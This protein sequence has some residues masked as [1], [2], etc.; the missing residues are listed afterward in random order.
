M[1]VEPVEQPGASTTKVAFGFK[2]TKTGRLAGAAAAE[3]LVAE[4]QNRR[5]QPNQPVAELIT[6]IEGDQVERL[7][8]QAASGSAADLDS[9]PVVPLLADK[10]DWAA[11]AKRRRIE[12]AA[13]AEASEADQLTKASPAVL[14]ILA[15]CQ[16]GSG[17]IGASSTN[18]TVDEVPLQ[19]NQQQDSNNDHQA[20]G[21]EDAEAE[22][23]DADYNAVA[24]ESFGLAALRGMGFKGT[25]EDLAKE[26]SQREVRLRPRGLGL[27]ADSADASGRQAAALASSAGADDAA[28]AD[29]QWKPGT[30]CRVT[31]GRDAGHCGTLVSADSDASRWLVAV[32]QLS[33]RVKSYPLAALELI[34]QR[35]FDKDSR[36]MNAARVNQY[37]AEQSRRGWLRTGCLVKVCATG[38]RLYGRRLRVL[39]ELRD[40]AAGRCV[41][42]GDNDAKPAV[43][44]SVG[45]LETAVPRRRDVRV[46]V[47]RGTL[48]GKLGR[49]A[50]DA[51]RDDG[52]RRRGLVRVR[53]RD[54]GDI[55]KLSMDD[56]CEYR[57]PVSG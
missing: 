54:S 49:T 20:G 47:V 24:V 23:E 32:A 12:A 45:E 52:L 50:D 43:E 39:D 30:R 27:G 21:E 51:D 1:S 33:G 13:A 22:P 53:L 37:R 34:G 5:Q 26:A 46:V 9:E 19:T 28:A 38:H 6:A 57:P 18:S 2:R 40:G 56:V 7:D 10:R 15:E 29:L 44:M 17:T 55:V 16:N 4:E 14:A 25:A 31:A 42:D 11:A 41:D 3:V 36:V 35:Q 48:A 8:G